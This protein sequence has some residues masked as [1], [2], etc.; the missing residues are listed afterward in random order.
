[1]GD[2][3]EETLVEEVPGKSTMVVANGDLRTILIKW[4]G[5][6]IAL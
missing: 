4:S 6:T 1:M 3:S 5:R 2:Q